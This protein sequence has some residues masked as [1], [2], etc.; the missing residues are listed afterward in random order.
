MHRD[1]QSLVEVN[2]QS[3]ERKEYSEGEYDEEGEYS[4][5][6]TC[7]SWLREKNADNA[8]SLNLSK[9]SYMPTHGQVRKIDSESN[10]NKNSV[11]FEEE[12]NLKRMMSNDH[13][14]DR[15]DEYPDDLS[16]G[17]YTMKMM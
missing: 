13:S 16:N 10:V 8:V 11:V 17:Q 7:S 9:Y 15:R 6:C 14:V 5:S 12:V 1:D 4:S 3:K 2:A